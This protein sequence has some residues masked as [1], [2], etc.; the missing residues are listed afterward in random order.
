MSR[1]YYLLYIHIIIIIISPF[2]PYWVKLWK[3]LRKVGWTELGTEENRARP[4]SL[5][6]SGPR[7]LWTSS[8]V[9]C[10]SFTARTFSSNPRAFRVS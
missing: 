4:W 6:Q 7:R 10:A 2:G 5:D 3:L 8:S 1:M 9:D